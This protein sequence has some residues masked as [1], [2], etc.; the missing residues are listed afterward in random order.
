MLLDV[1][2]PTLY[3]KGH[4]A[5]AVNL[6]HGKI[7]ASKMTEYAA[8]TL[9][10]TYCNGPHCNGTARRAL[11]LARLGYPAK[12]MAGGITGWLDGGFTLKSGLSQ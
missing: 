9:F 4:I 11:H 7:I 10:V 6:P 3:E 5:G 12:I 8:S 1:R 2:S